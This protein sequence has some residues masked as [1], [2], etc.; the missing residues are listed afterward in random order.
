M[1]K[2]EALHIGDP[3]DPATVIGPL[4]NQ[5]ALSLIARRVDEAVAAGARLLTGGTPR[6]PCFPPTEIGRAHV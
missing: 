5:W 1:A 4:I 2:V 3:G 6:P